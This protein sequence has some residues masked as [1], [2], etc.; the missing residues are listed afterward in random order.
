MSRSARRFGVPMPMTLT[1]T[2]GTERVKVVHGESAV[3]VVATKALLVVQHF[4]CMYA[5]PEGTTFQNA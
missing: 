5:Q 3:R 2:E 1:A 4:P